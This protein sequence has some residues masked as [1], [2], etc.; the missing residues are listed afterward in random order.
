MIQ[1]SHEL[2]VG[3]VKYCMMVIT[4]A[5]KHVLCIVKDSKSLNW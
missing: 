4:N 3:S 5:Y 1:V 2:F